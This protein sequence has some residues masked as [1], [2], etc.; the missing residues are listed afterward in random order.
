MEYLRG[1]QSADI[2]RIDPRLFEANYAPEYSVVTA[3]VRAHALNVR[4]RP[5]GDARSVGQLPQGEKVYVLDIINKTW[6]EIRTKKG[7]GFV[8]RKWLK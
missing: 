6:V 1:L 3:Y 8:P 7:T 2:A 4:S 5:S